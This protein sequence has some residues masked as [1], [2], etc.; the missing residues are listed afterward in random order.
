MGQKAAKNGP[1]CLSNVKIAFIDYLTYLE[2]LSKIL[3]K[4]IDLPLY[5]RGDP[6]PLQDRKGRGWGAPPPAKYGPVV[7]LLMVYVLN[8][9]MVPQVETCIITF[10]V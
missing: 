1:I 9:A 7:M 5:Q 8:S 2:L 6:L 10:T 3:H 4:P